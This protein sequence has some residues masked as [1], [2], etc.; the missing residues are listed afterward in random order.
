MENNNNTFTTDS[1]QLASFLLSEQCNLLALDRSNP[2]RII[3]IFEETLLR[4]ELT[5]KFLSHQASVEP[6]RFASAQ[7][8]LKQLI[9]QR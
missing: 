4:Q 6:H 1:F 8:D 2:K 3:F 5:Q 9:Y 7:K